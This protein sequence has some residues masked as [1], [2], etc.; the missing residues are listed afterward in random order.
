VI[1]ALIAVEIDR[2]S[3][4]MRIFHLAL[5][6]A[7]RAS[8]SVRGL[9]SI[10]RPAPTPHFPSPFGATREVLAGSEFTSHKTPFAQ[11]DVV[12]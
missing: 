2:S 4:D 9:L 3:R 11:I 10:K 6:K 8:L 7:S 12:R 1:H 5:L